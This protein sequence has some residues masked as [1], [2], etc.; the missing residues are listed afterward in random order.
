MSKCFSNTCRFFHKPEFGDHSLYLMKISTEK[1]LKPLKIED[2]DA[3]EEETYCRLLKSIFNQSIP[4][5]MQKIDLA[6][7][8]IESNQ[9]TKQLKIV[10]M[11]FENNKI[12]KF[13]SQYIESHKHDLD[14]TFVLQEFGVA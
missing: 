2:R 11:N 6:Q 12:H 4:K 13:Y 1:Y 8:L 10:M 9:L 5:M 7:R 14:V 3:F